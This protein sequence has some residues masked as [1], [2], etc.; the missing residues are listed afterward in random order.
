MGGSRNVK[1]SGVDSSSLCSFRVC[2]ATW[3]F[4]G[5]CRYASVWFVRSGGNVI[6]LGGTVY[7]LQPSDYLLSDQFD[8]ADTTLFCLYADPCISKYGLY[9][10]RSRWVLS[11][12][13]TRWWKSRRVIGESVVTN[14]TYR[15]NGKGNYSE[16]ILLF[17]KGPFR[18]GRRYWQ[19]WSVPGIRVILKACPSYSWNNEGRSAQALW[20]PDFT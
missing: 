6:Y 16:F 13:G 5:H 12:S 1:I 14:R 10:S 4:T 11:H 9:T 20:S 18:N 2:G 7:L 17:L 8:Q 3:Y 15:G 19:L